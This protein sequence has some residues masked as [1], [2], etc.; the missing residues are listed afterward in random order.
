VPDEPPRGTSVRGAAGT[1]DITPDRPVRLAGMARRRV[2]SVRASE[3]LSANAMLFEDFRGRL[4][5]IL[6]LDLLFA[7][8]DLTDRLRDFAAKELNIAKGD[9]LIAASHTH[10]APPVDRRKPALGPVD[11]DY[12]EWVT[13]RC[14]ELLR[15][16]AA[17]RR[18][19]LCF[20]G[21]IAEW[22]GAVYRRRYWPVPHLTREGPSLR[23]IVLAPDHDRSISRDV[24]LLEVTD[25]AGRTVAVIWSAACHPTGWPS[26][27][28]QSP[29]YIGIVRDRL[30]AMPGGPGPVPVLFLQGFA[31][32][33]RPDVPDGR[34]WI[35]RAGRAVLFGPNFNTFDAATWSAWSDELAATLAA[36]LAAFRRQT[37]TPLVGRLAG[38]VVELPLADVLDGPNKSGRVVEFQ[39]LHLGTMCDIL[40]VSAEPSSMLLPLLDDPDIWPTGY[41]GDVFGYWPTDLQRQEGGYEGK[42]WIAHFSLR[43]S[44]RPERDRLFRKTLSALSECLKRDLQDL[45]DVPVSPRASA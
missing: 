15:S 24:R 43:G 6:S 14:C 18:E 21:G 13:Q 30:A 3:K 41:S 45:S 28:G 16:V 37:A 27:H 7:G 34:S 29:D 1:V 19:P 2:L 22:H 38:A 35:R 33:L 42:G 39:R 40:A 17:Q 8:P 4:Q 31:G 5:G 10:S 25:D 44:L 32:D 12:L 36:A 26:Q 11:D 9:L 23:G 20:R